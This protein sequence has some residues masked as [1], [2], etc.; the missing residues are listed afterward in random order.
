MQKFYSN[1][2]LLISGEYL[3]L[4]GAAG[5]A[6]PSVFGQDLRVKTVNQNNTLSWTSLDENE[7]IWFEAKFSLPE[8]TLIDVNGDKKV[9]DTLVKILQE[10]KKSNPKFLNDSKGLH[11]TTKLFFPR[12]W[13]L[14]S[15]STLINNIAQWAG[16]DAFELLFK[17]F[18]GSGYDIACAQNNQSIIYQLKQGTPSVEKVAFNPSFKDQLYFVHLNKKQVS[19]ESIKAYKT[20]ELD[21]KA[22]DEI[23]DISKKILS[24]HTISDF[25]NYLK[26]HENL[27]SSVLNEPTVQQRFFSDFKGQT[28]SLG[29]WGGDFILA[30]GDETTIDYFKLKG[31]HTVIPY[32]SMIKT[33]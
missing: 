17:S 10:A 28:K 29:A 27:L 20:A 1:G 12:D 9:A 15:S 3:I 16:I 6:L 14:G 13:G 8:L 23:T 26:E 30:T 4:D 33:R 19:S 5:L 24:A 25:N 31:Y 2:K 32:T 21:L 7:A 11:V 18:G 22:V